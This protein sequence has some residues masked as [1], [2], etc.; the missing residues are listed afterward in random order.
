MLVPEEELSRRREEEL[1]R[2]DKAFTAPKRTREVSKSLKAYAK[3]VS[4]A[5]RGA[6]RIID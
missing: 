3:M 1:R 2:G 6:V 5:D 4:S